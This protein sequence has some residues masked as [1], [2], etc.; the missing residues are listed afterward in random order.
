MRIRMVSLETFRLSEVGEA[1][2]GLYGHEESV[3]DSR[4]FGKG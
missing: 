3:R 4:T 2:M 1:R